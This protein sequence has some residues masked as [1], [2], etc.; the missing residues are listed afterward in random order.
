MKIVVIN[1]AGG[2]GKDLFVAFC[3]SI[4]GPD[5]VKNY[6]TVDYVKAVAA[7][8]GWDGT[9]DDKNRRFLSELKR[10]LTEWDDIPYRRTRIEIED[11]EEKMYKM[12]GKYAENSV[13]FIHCREPEEI[14]RFVEEFNAE[15]LLIRRELAEE[16]NWENASDKGVLDYSY[17]Y[18]VR[19]EG[20]LDDLRESAR[21][22]LRDCLKLDI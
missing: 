1:G 9:K 13:M 16:K 2:V 14:Q 10:V 8:I 20:T 22:F 11:F 15:T 21:A 5:K 4:L 3:A 19:N 18:I 6:S 7:H 17:N 12:G